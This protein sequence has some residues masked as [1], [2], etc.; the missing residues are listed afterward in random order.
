MITHTHTLLE[1]TLPSP[2]RDRGEDERKEK[3]IGDRAIAEV[4]RYEL[5]TDTVWTDGSRS[6]G[7]RDCLLHPRTTT[8]GPP[9]SQ[10]TIAM[11]RPQAW[12]TGPAVDLQRQGEAH[13]GGAQPNR[14]ERQRF[15]PGHVGRRPTMPS[16]LPSRRGYTA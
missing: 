6:S 12:E 7:R 10:A 15:F 14:L 4:Q 13:L 11:E 2:I 3:K 9:H 5:D 16:S 1:F 8:S